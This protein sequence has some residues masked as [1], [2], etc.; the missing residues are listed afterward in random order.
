MAN[1][2]P[3]TGLLIN[4]TI[5]TIDTDGDITLNGNKLITGG[6]SGK[7]I[8]S[9]NFTS[10]TDASGKQA[11][12]GATD[13]YTITYTD[14]TTT[15]FNVY[16]G[17][18][19]TKGDAGVGIA[20]IS[21]TSTTDASGK[22]AQ[23]GATDTYTITYTDNTTSTFNVYNGKDGTSGVTSING[24]TGD[25]VINKTSVDLGNVDNTSDINKPISL[26]TQKALDLKANLNGDNT[27]T[28]KVADA[29]ED[30]EAINKGQFNSLLPKTEAPII[31]VALTVNENDNTTI[32]ISNYDSSCSYN[33]TSDVGTIAYTSGV[34]A[35]FTAMD[36]TNQTNHI[37]SI[38]CYATS[39]GE[40]RSDNCISNITIVYVPF[41]SDQTLSNAD[42]ATNVQTSSGFTF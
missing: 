2:I 11:Q 15:T 37:G 33:F 6:S 26:D 20:N 41:V 27:Q 7:G 25:V 13:T 14:N 16:N 19:G 5:V 40:I 4:N 21:F 22:V 38:T 3:V 32:T 28:F 35:T 42:Y 8:L 31:N 10:T 36:I 18:D 29:I 9:I 39:E 17:V 1:E 23:S 34:T 24:N 30:D 12:S